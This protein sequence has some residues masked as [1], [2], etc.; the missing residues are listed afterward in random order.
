MDL[1]WTH[2]EQAFRAEA[3]A[4]LAEHLELWREQCGG[5]IHSGDTHDGFAQHMTSSPLPNTP[6]H[7]VLM[8][9]AVGD[10]QVANV[11]AEVEA[12]TIGAHLYVPALDP[13]RSL[14]KTPFY[15]IPQISSYP[16]VPV[17]IRTTSGSCSA[18][19]DRSSTVCQQLG[20]CSSWCAKGRP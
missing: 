10:H 14:D 2:A 20:D 1:T 7:E 8:Q 12:R 3:R 5:V 15:A 19:K 16:C 13:G 6:A 18:A 17:H 9:A 11:S 4:W